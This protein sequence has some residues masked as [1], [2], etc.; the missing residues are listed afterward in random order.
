M[1]SLTSEV[2]I[3]F[4]VFWGI[5]ILIPMMVD[6]LSALVH[7]SYA[8]FK[9][10]RIRRN[11]EDDDFS[12][13]YY[14]LVSVLVP[15]HNSASTLYE[16][17]ESI[18]AQ[19]YPWQRLEVLLIDN[20][21]T[22]NSFDVFNQFTGR[23]PRLRCRWVSFKQSGKSRALNAGICMGKGQYL[24]TVDSDSYLVPEAI[25]ETIKAFS[26][27]VQLVGTTGVI[28]INHDKIEKSRSALRLMQICEAFEYI[29]AFYIAR[30]FQSRFNTLFT[31]AGAFSGFRR[32]ALL[33]TFLYDN[34][35]VSED[36]KLTFDLRMQNPGKNR[37]IMV[38]KS[39]ALVAPINSLQHLYSQRLRWQR[40]QLEVAAYFKEQ[41]SVSIFRLLSSFP[42]RT[43]FAD[44]TLAFPRMAWFFLIPLLFFMGYPLTLVLGANLIIYLLY[45]IIDLIYILI[46]LAYLKLDYRQF[47]R[48]NFWI[49]IVLPLYRFIVYWCR[50][51]G[52]ITA[53]TVHGEWDSSGPITQTR[54]AFNDL[55]T[56][57]GFK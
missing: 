34:R 14:P 2:V 52:I 41:N 26:R 21:T 19:T 24:V 40:G 48:K 13:N 43:L 42:S 1:N 56:R 22:D 11:C 5:W 47:V 12:L 54:Q 7:T 32:L 45:V 15:V 36:T 3:K 9:R 53:V 25:T 50:L 46:A 17:L 44:H 55:V 10:V 37:L 33:K 6:G 29:E 30:S 8:I 20:G 18:A 16:C 51:A 38:E 4:L 27:D 57:M 35:T 28:L 23:Y 31:M 49:V 39:V